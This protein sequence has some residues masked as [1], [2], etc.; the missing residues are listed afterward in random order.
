MERSQWNRFS[1]GKSVYFRNKETGEEITRRQYEKRRHGG[2]NYEQRAK[3]RYHIETRKYKK[4]KT[5]HRSYTLDKTRSIE[6]Q[7]NKTKQ[8]Y[9]AYI[10]YTDNK[11]GKQHQSRTLSTRSSGFSAAGASAAAGLVSEYHADDDDDDSDYELEAV[12][13]HHA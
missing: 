5:E 7:L 1:K 11:T 10:R 13:I 8:G 6:D 3:E 2:K 4:S 12:Y 9:A